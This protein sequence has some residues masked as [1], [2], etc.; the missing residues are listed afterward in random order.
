M[1]LAIV[2][3]H[4]IQYQAPLFREIARRLDLTVFY[5]HRASAKDQAGAGFGVGLEWDVDLL[6]GY[7]H[8][9]LENVS[10][11]PGLEKFGGCD[12]PT[13]DG[14]IARG[15]FDAVLVT[16]WQFRSYV[17]AIVA[18]K[19]RG[20]PVMA[21]GDSQLVTPRSAL[22]KFAKNLAYPALLRVFDAALYV[23]VRSRLYWEH[24]RFPSDR[25]FFSPHCVDN[26][27]FR[28][29]ASNIARKELREAHGIP[30]DA[31]VALFAGKLVPFK[32][33]ADLILAAGELNLIG[34]E[35]I[36]L[37]AGSGVL[38]NKL[39]SMARG[40]S[41]RLVELG[42]CNQ[43]QMPAAFAA[44]DVLVLPSDG[45]ETWGLVANEALASGIPIITSD[46]C[47]CSS[48]LCCDP[49]VGRVF[50]VGNVSALIDCLCGVLEASRA[51][52]AIA[53]VAE[54]YSL[55]KAADGVELALERIVRR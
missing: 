39:A 25:L 15:G 34:K 29:R 36:V 41:V 31:N 51:S 7:E 53:A 52:E 14:E 22:K 9:F 54:S 46:A 37:A 20:I 28:A 8:R 13:I 4:P 10:T 17:Q 49:R 26:D 11:A 19:R 42:F 24:Y 5:A 48:D 1:R 12:T 33:P 2:A 16:G 27:W 30:Q 6:A 23:G 35:L 47:G 18:A 44:A 43:S 40:A 55:G 21:R 38:R 45:R 3:S 50:P 32:R